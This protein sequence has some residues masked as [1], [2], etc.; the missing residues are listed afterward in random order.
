MLA[1]PVVV[2]DSRRRGSCIPRSV[3]TRGTLLPT[4]R[5][6]SR[7]PPRLRSRRRCLP[8]RA[9]LTRTFD[10]RCLASG[11]PPSTSLTRLM[12]RTMFTRYSLALQTLSGT[13]VGII[14]LIFYLSDTVYSNS[15]IFVSFW[16]RFFAD[17]PNSTLFIK[18]IENCIQ[19]STHLVSL[20]RKLLDEGYIFEFYRKPNLLLIEIKID[21]MNC[22]AICFYRKRNS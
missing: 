13:Y 11:F 14:L 5:A 18:N 8:L 3:H 15:Y 6:R 16:H 2:R 10:D 22:N 12:T 21:F 4:Q 17:M 20:Q 19:F 7:A 1:R 9:P